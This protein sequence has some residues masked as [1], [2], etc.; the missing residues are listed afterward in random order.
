MKKIAVISSDIIN[1]SQFDEHAFMN[2]MHV[3][4]EPAGNYLVSEGEPILSSRGDSFQL[5]TTD[6]QHSFMKAIYLKALF[7]KKQVGL[8]DGKQ[9]GAIDIRI[10]LAVGFAKEIPDHIGKSMEEPFVLSGRALDQMK[11]RKQSFIITTSNDDYNKDL[12]LV[13]AF[14]DHLFDS[15]TLAQAEVIYYLVQ[16][17]KQ[18]EIADILNLSQPSVSNRIQLANWKLIEKTNRR[19]LEIVEKL[20]Q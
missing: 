18:T 13:C 6:I 3:L 7:R 19:F 8:K 20:E 14:L 1:S 10:S 15:W 16:G 4:E 17:Y 5:M 12:E 2:T 9:K 11:K